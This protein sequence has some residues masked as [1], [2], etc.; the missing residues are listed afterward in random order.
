MLYGPTQSGP[1]DATRG[2]SQRVEFRKRHS[3]PETDWRDKA[4]RE[5]G[6]KWAEKER[7]SVSAVKEA[8]NRN[9]S[10]NNV[11]ENGAVS[12]ETIG[13]WEQ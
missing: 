13:E 9:E 10:R 4:F 5:R 6:T 7:S 12:Q 1:K 11:E 3:T 8:Q 2:A